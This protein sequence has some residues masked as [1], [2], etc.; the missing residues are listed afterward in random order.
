[1]DL[2]TF[3]HS[4]FLTALGN[5]ILNSLW[6]GFLLWIVYQ[7]VLVFRKNTS[8][9]LKHNLSVLSVFASFAWFLNTLFSK[10]FFTNT[11]RVSAEIDNLQNTSS[12]TSILNSLFSFSAP[13][14]PYLSIAYILLLF[15]LMIKLFSAYKQVH[16][17]AQRNLIIPPDH[18]LHFS[19]KVASHLKINKRIQIWISNS[20]QVPATI[21]FIKPAILIPLASINNL[22]ADQLEAIILHEFSHIKRNDYLI[23]LWMSFIETVLFFN[24]FIACFIKV[25]KQERE[26]CCDDLVL[27]YRYDPHS[28]ASALLNLEHARYENVQLALGAVSGKK[29]LLARIKRITG[30]GA[31]NHFN[32]AQKL[33]AL[34]LTTAIFCCLGWISSLKVKK[35]LSIHTT[36]ITIAK[37]TINSVEAIVQKSGD[38]ETAANQNTLPEVDSKSKMNIVK[39]KKD[40]NIMVKQKIKIKDQHLQNV[41]IDLNGFD[42]NNQIE[43][44]LKQAFIE[45]NKI[46]W[47]GVEENIKKSFEEINVEDLPA[48]EREALLLAKKYISTLNMQRSSIKRE[49]LINELKKNEN[50]VDSLRKTGWLRN[51]QENRLIGPTTKARIQILNNPSEFFAYGFNSNN[52][53]ENK[54]SKKNSEKLGRSRTIEI[55]QDNLQPSASP[56]PSHPDRPAFRK[57]NKEQKII[58]EI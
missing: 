1:M 33:F 47:K 50:V 57:S 48:K 28:Y 15:L 13:V 41:T 37:K 35:E 29:E 56:E 12:N 40:T 43:N 20:I 5:A 24:P 55:F 7:L 52:N 39:P 22:S 26:N 49:Q 46:D 2:S 14:L 36:S 17:I 32:Y 21:G 38:V 8:S 19:K 44:G 30:T 27:E 51:I 23:N 4:L 18:L 45:I 6:Q 31:V 16:S 10:L 34:L 9:K 53:V 58:I 25:I 42:F 54:P 11:I 3:Q